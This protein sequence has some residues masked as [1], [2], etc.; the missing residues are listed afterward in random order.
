MQDAKFNVY[1]I[2][3]IGGTIFPYHSL[4]RIFPKCVA[5]YGIEYDISYSAKSVKELAAFYADA[6]RAVKIV[7]FLKDVLRFMF[8]LELPVH[9]YLV[10]H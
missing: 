2:H 7:K 4:L 5:I 6:V 3:A 10:T 1:L 8:I 9:F